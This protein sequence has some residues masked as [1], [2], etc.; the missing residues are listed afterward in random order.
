MEMHAYCEDYLERARQILGDMMDFAVNTCEMNPDD[1]FTKFLVTGI[2][3]QFGRGNPRYVS[4]ITGC[5]LVREVMEKSGFPLDYEE[6][7]MYLDKSPEYWSGWALCYYQWF[8]GHSFSKIHQAVPME[9][10]LHMYPTLHE[11]DIIKF[12]SVMD[13]KMKSFYPETNLKRIRMMV[14][15]SQ[16]E[17]AELSGVSLR[18]IQLFE[19]RQRDINK[20]QVTNVLRL[21]GALGCRMEEL[22]ER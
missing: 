6:D 16:S 3:E 2:A 14:G 8:S 7:E 15:L 19:Q 18:Q 1:Y 10:I 4:G 22:V 11:A 13:E 21:A 12:V 9:K 5:E 17:L 20:T